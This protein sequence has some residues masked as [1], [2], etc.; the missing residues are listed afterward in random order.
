MSCGYSIFG[1]DLTA[2]DGFSECC[3]NAVA[4]PFG[5]TAA[6]IEIDE[7]APYQKAKILGHISVGKLVH[8]LLQCFNVTITVM[9]EYL[10]YLHCL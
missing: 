8:I 2:P 9:F 1:G 7:N 4:S 3:T 5:V 6:L 10:F